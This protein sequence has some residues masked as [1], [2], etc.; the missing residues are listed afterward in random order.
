MTFTTS[1][2]ATL[3]G[4]SK[5][6]YAFSRAL[7]GRLHWSRE[8]SSGTLSTSA[9]SKRNEDPIPKQTNDVKGGPPFCYFIRSSK[10]SKAKANATTTTTKRNP[11]Y[12]ELQCPT[13]DEQ[14]WRDFEATGSG[15]G[16]QTI[17]QKNSNSN[18][19][20]KPLYTYSKRSC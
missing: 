4:D 1:P 20:W 16:A 11:E 18:V 14:V 13:P 7:C 3:F 9:A 2:S 10:A 5:V 12:L 19:I 6:C 8:L 17:H 15:C